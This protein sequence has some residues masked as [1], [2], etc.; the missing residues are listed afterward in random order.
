MRKAWSVSEGGL[1]FNV[2]DPNDYFLF[3]TGGAKLYIMSK[4][5]IC[6][7]EP[8]GY[9]KHCARQIKQ[10]FIYKHGHE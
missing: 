5:K 7:L 3:N 9:K 8:K 2:E 4:G 10:A 1:R 6:N